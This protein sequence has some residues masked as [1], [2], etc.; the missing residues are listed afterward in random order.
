MEQT[1]STPYT[2]I[3]LALV[4]GA[5]SIAGE[6]LARICTKILR[7]IHAD[8]LR[9]SRRAVLDALPLG[10][11]LD[12]AADAH[13]LRDPAPLGKVAGIVERGF[14]HARPGQAAL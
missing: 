2:L 11:N 14:L 7:E 8:F 10:R 6:I 1:M 9:G 5:L 12:L 3:E 13:L 4:A